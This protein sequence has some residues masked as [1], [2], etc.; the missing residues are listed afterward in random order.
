VSLNFRI[1]TLTLPLFIYTY[2]LTSFF[3]LKTSLVTNFYDT[4]THTHLND[5]LLN[6]YYFF[7]TQFFLLPSLLL[8]ILYLYNTFFMKNKNIMESIPLVLLSLFLL[9]WVFEY[10]LVNNYSYK[11]LNLPYSFNNL[12]YNSLNKYHPIIFFFSYIYIY[13][14]PFFLNLYQN[15]RNINYINS[16]F[17][18][19]FKLVSIRYNIYWFFITFALYLGAW[20]A[21]QEGSWGGWWNWDSSEVFGLV[22]L[23]FV[24]Y[25]FH[26]YIPFIPYIHNL[27]KS[28]TWSLVLLFLY[29]ILQMSYTLVSHNFGLNILDYGYVNTNFLSTSILVFFIYTFIQYIVMAISHRIIML[30]G[31]RRLTP[32]QLSAPSYIYGKYLYNYVLIFVIF[33]I[34]S[35]SFNPIINNILW[36]SLDLE[37]LNR[38]FTC[39]NVQLISLLTVYVLFYRINSLNLLFLTTFWTYS[40]VYVWLTPVYTIYT[41]LK[42]LLLHILLFLAFS[43]SIYLNSSV[44]ILWDYDSIMSVTYTNYRLRNPYS[45]SLK[46]DSLYVIDFIHT[47]SSKLLL[48]LTN[49]FFWLNNNPSIQ[50]FVLDTTDTTLRQTIL[51]HSYLYTFKVSIQDTAPYLIDLLFTYVLAISYFFLSKKNIIIF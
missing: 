31:I 46:V 36:T 3:F 35:I 18:F 14:V 29:T 40:F 32:K 48:N 15:Y 2:Y 37:L 39:V 6:N 20:W 24:L 17:L 49:S 9:W 25:S 45:T 23:T 43:T 22:V 4:F 7:W 38:L 27:F 19:K 34:Y 28:I 11:H 12:L 8:Y 13:K 30:V 10:Y 47:V 50:Y 16:L 33:Y 5:F 21:L 51:N 26:L 1:Y 44:F 42:I 41:N